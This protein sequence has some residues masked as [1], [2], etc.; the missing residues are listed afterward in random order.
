MKIRDLMELTTQMPYYM[1]NMGRKY[2]NIFHPA[3]FVFPM[4]V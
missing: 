4:E 2:Y 1:G 3:Y